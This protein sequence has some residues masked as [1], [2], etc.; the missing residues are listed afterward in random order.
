MSETEPNSTPSSAFLS[1]ENSSPLPRSVSSR[2]RPHSVDTTEQ[3]MHIKHGLLP[4]YNYRSEGH[5][6]SVLFQ[7]KTQTTITHHSKGFSVYQRRRLEGTFERQEPTRDID[8]LLHA[9]EYDLYVGVC[10][11][12]LKL[13]NKSFECVYERESDSRIVTAVYNSW[14]GEIITS[15]AGNITV[16][17]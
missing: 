9:E 17:I 2:L 15:G 1:Q 4:D 3:G 11:Y 14:S 5:V 7:P 6:C 10:R 12:H 13:L 16:I 8:M